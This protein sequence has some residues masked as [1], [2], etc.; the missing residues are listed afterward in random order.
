MKTLLWHFVVVVVAV[1]AVWLGG[2]LLC[3]HSYTQPHIHQ[4][5]VELWN[6]NLCNFL[7]R[8]TYLH[9]EQVWFH[10]VQCHQQYTVI[11]SA[12]TWLELDWLCL[13]FKLDLMFFFFLLFFFLLSHLQQQTQQ[14]RVVRAAEKRA[15]LT[16]EGCRLTE[17]E[18]GNSHYPSASNLPKNISASPP[19]CY[20]QKRNRWCNLMRANY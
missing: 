5:H 20:K 6:K 17:P 12:P 18:A 15:V 8:K 3:G 2:K 7:S 11:T 16:A 9:I 1:V 19:F 13:I 4:K 14:D 10:C